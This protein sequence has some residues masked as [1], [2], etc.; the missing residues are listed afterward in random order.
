[1]NP[2]KKYVRTELRKEKIEKEG[3]RREKRNE[4]DERL[5]R[6]REGRSADFVLNNYFW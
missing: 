4:S 6:R 1:L 5:K 2:Q 3:K